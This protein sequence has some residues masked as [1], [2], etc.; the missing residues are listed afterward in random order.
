MVLIERELSFAQSTD[1]RQKGRSVSHE[2]R[3]RAWNREQEAVW[4]ELLSYKGIA[5]D[6][7]YAVITTLT[8]SGGNS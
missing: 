6:T 5:A 3:E 8:R 4:C 1:V 7:L 2:T